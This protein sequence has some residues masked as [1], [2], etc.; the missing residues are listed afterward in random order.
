MEK[1]WVGQSTDPSFFSLPHGIKGKYCRRKCDETTTYVFYN[2]IK[3][4]FE[5]TVL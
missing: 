4:R 5:K 3:G 2:F 1:G